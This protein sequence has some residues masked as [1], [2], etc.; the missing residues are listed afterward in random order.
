MKI[1]YPERCHHKEF[2]EYFNVG[3]QTFMDNAAKKEEQIFEEEKIVLAKTFE[4]NAVSLAV[5][6][7][8]GLRKE[9]GVASPSASW[10]IEDSHTET[11]NTNH[12]LYAK[13]QRL[14]DGAVVQNG[15]TLHDRSVTVLSLQDSMANMVET[16][17][18]GLIPGQD[19]TQS[20]LTKEQLDERKERRKLSNRESA[21]RSRLRK[22]QENKM[23]QE[24]AMKLQHEV[25]ELRDGVV[26]IA[27]KCHQLTEENI[28]LLDDLEKASCPNDAISELKAR[29]HALVNHRKRS[30]SSDSDSTDDDQ[31]RESTSHSD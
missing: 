5:Y 4:E 28:S 24:R 7:D 20:L 22:Q 31:I 16:K 12:N 23:L 9:G 15:D 30:S 27:E 13:R 19:G 1:D 3:L 18:L 2:E 21:K 29:F 17:N 14:C 6:G 10:G 11:N 8:N 25:S 26:L